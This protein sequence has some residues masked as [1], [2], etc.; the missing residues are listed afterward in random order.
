VIISLLHNHTHYDIIIMS[1]LIVS[2][3]SHVIE[4]CSCSG[5]LLCQDND[6]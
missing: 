1:H 2:F 4:F 3:E 5:F 6:F